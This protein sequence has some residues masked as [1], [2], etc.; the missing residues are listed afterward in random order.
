MKRLLIVDDEDKIREV[1]REYAEFSGYEAEEAA[2]GMSAIG[3]VKL[4]DYALSRYD[5][6]QQSIFKNAGKNYFAV[7]M[8][9]PRYWKQ[10]TRD[11]TAKYKPLEGER[12]EWRGPIIIMVSIFMLVYIGI[13]VLLSNLIMRLIPWFMR[14][15][16][17]KTAEKFE[18]KVTSRIIDVKEM[19]YKKLPIDGIQKVANHGGIGYRHIWFCHHHHQG[20]PLEQPLHHGHEPHD[21]CGVAYG[22]GIRFIDYQA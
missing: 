18:L 17:P 16:F 10:M 8:N 22:G 3:M 13:A 20:I 4:N 15:F 14:K 11:F 7:L 5:Y 21:H 12:S 9:L 1:I 6:L 2:D 19:E